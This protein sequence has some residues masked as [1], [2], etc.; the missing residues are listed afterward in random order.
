[1]QK[2]GLIGGM[3]P[4][5]TMPYYH[6]IVYGV[7]EKKE[8]FPEL[9]L[10]SVDVFKVLDLCGHKKYDDLTEYLLQALQHLAAGGADFA[11]LS[12]N[13][14]HIV[15]DSLQKK[16]P[17]PLI[18]IIG[19]AVEEAKNKQMKKLGLI[20]TRFTMEE[21]F[22]KDKFTANN[23]EIVIPN[24]EE[25]EYIGD[26]IPHELE[27]GIV[28]PETKQG[29]IHIAQRMIDKENVDG[30]ILGCTELPL[31][32]KDKIKLSVPYLDTMQIHVAALVETII[33]N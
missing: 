21:K 3:G 1:M 16:S 20:G 25:R 11:A 8:K 19:T 2:L 28:K 27:L 18:S 10:E 12:A 17:L 31:V 30:I 22:F 5:S 7:Y 14:P 6:D 32:F 23:I 26:K 33:K 24:D 13:T 9:L 29:F 15:F 4:E